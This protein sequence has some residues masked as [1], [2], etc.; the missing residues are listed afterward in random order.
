MATDIEKARVIAEKNQPYIGAGGSLIPNVT[1]AVVEGIKLG[2]V[3][4]LELAARMIND[5]LQVAKDGD[6]L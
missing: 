3:D 6:G 4:G 1:R 5:A 2:R